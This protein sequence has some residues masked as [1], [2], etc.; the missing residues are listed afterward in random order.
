MQITLGQTRRKKNKSPLQRRF[1]K[2]VRQL[3][4]ESRQLERLKT[5]LD[6]LTH[7]MH[8]VMREVDQAHAEELVTL[9][10]RLSVFAGRKSLSDWHRHELADWFGVLIR[11]IGAID[12][13]ARERLIDD[14]EGALARLSGMEPEEYWAMLDEVF[15]PPGA[16][17]EDEASWQEGE[18]AVGDPDA[19]FQ[20]DLFGRETEVEEG[21]DIGGEPFDEPFDGI[22]GPD[23]DQQRLDQLLDADWIKGL[24]RK[25]TQRLHPDREADPETREHKQKLMSKLLEARR[26]GDVLT[27]L[28]IAGEAMGEDSLIL[29]E[30]QMAAL[31]E[32]LQARLD[33]IGHERD[34]FILGNPSRAEAYE[35]LYSPSAKTRERNLKRWRR[36][37]EGEVA[38]EIALAARLRNLTLLKDALRA[39]RDFRYQLKMEMLSALF[40]TAPRAD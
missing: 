35:T 20:D 32:A 3:E 24:F 36:E 6:R 10:G 15:N 27:L 26:G 13:A 31:C 23:P 4:R 19:P 8:E 18:D 2:L 39:R 38:A 37:R 7:R 16:G 40:D 25:A 1:D 11:R 29:A 22:S 14:F 28:R 21:T 34:L 12:P 33:A 30:E 17:Q 9:A 5:E